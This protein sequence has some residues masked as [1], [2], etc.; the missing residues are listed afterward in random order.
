MERRS[1]VVHPAVS[2]SFTN[3]TTSELRTKPIAS[4]GVSVDWRSDVRFCSSS[5]D[6]SVGNLRQEAETRRRDVL[7]LGHGSRG[8]S[9]RRARV[10]F[11]HK[12]TSNIDT[13]V[14]QW[15]LT[16]RI[17]QTISYLS[18]TWTTTFC[19]VA[20]LTKISILMNTFDGVSRAWVG[21][22]MIELHTMPKSIPT[23]DEL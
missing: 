6:V 20:K 17:D 15:N 5:H 3:E 13:K 23:N 12:S 9:R 14:F 11:R 1:L 4:S 22:S 8:L 16:P 2:L 19:V 21:R 7:F 18:L 10:N